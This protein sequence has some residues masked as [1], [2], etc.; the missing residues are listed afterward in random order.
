MI[1]PSQKKCSTEPELYK[2]TCFSDKNHPSHVIICPPKTSIPCLR[3]TVFFWRLAG[4]VMRR[5]ERKTK[6]RC[7][8][9]WTELLRR[10][11]GDGWRM[12]GLQV[13][14]STDVPKDLYRCLPKKGISPN[15]ARDGIHPCKVLNRDLVHWAW[16]SRLVSRHIW[17]MMWWNLDETHMISFIQTN[18]IGTPCVAFCFMGSLP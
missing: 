13:E 14:L 11:A 7:W 15:Q 12:D 6:R 4:L 3:Q 16:R 17:L 5:R 2:Q 8:I 1:S 18:P 10:C 9:I